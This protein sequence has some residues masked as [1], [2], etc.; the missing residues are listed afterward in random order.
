MTTVPISTFRADQPIQFSHQ[1][2]TI[3]NHDNYLLWKSQVLPVLRGYDL[4]GFI[5]GSHPSPPSTIVTDGVSTVNSTY[6]KWNQQDKLILAWLFSSISS[7]VLAQV[8]NAST[9]HQLWQQL[10]NIHSSQSI[11][12]VREL[13]LLLQTTKKENSSCLQFIQQI[14]AIADR[15]RSIGSEITDQ[16][17]VLYTLQG[18]GSDYDAFVITF[19]MRQSTAS[20]SDLQSLL[21]AHEARVHA[22]LSVHPVSAHLTSSSLSANSNFTPEALFAGGSSVKPFPPSKGNQGSFF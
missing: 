1:I 19:S 21:L 20:M 14:Q 10:Q 3:L 16:D 15:L 8:L 2:H 17:L 22:N 12:K 13:K 11:A 6:A 9:S 18:L 4:I 7:P 5:D